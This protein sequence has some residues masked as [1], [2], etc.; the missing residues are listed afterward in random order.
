V[1]YGK[2]ELL[3]LLSFLTQMSNLAENGSNT[4]QESNGKE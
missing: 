1:I 4:F 2:N 3:D